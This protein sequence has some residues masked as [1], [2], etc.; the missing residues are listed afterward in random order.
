MI[1]N[2]SQPGGIQTKISSKSAFNESFLQWFLYSNMAVNSLFSQYFD[3]EGFSSLEVGILMAV[4]PLMSLISTPFWF[5][6]GTKI[7]DNRTF[8]ITALSS[9]ALIWMVFLSDGFVLKLLSFFLV[10]FFMS[11]LV[12]LGD[13]TVIKSL[14]SKGLGFDRA[15]FWGTAG[16]ACMALLIGAFL[17]YGFYTFF[18]FASTFMLICFFAQGKIKVVNVEE[19]EKAAGGSGGDWLTFSL[20][21]VG[22]YLGISLV[23]FNNTFFP[24]LSR[25]LGYGVSAAGMGFAIMGFS[26]LPF[27]FFA[28]KILKRF[29]H[30]KLLGVGIFITG[31]R[32]FLMST[33]SFQPLMMAIQ[34][35]HGFT[36]IVIYYSMFNFIHYKLPVS[37]KV[38]AQTIF[39]MVNLG[40]SF[41]S[42]SVLGGFIVDGI[43]TISSYRYL[44]IFGMFASLI[45]VLPYLRDKR[46]VTR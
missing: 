1:D 36:Y 31:L 33:I 3:S 20:M 22:T 35:L 7:T 15:R 6:V 37:M 16:Y 2:L 25:E 9:S 41:I 42:G 45:V 12:P 18:A 13:A 21:L 46:R 23:G 30:F 29:G 17:H 4:F 8:R 32:V 39:W 26:E 34:F 5:K 28:D 14:Q 38:K 19:S 11:A 24:I 27:L 40:L 44:G 43:G 10:S